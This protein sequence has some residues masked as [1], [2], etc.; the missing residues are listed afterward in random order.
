MCNI[1]STRGNRGCLGIPYFFALTVHNARVH[2]GVLKAN[3]A[4]GGC[5]R[6]HVATAP[7]G[8]RLAG[9][10]ASP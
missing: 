3:K 5:R 8:L 9:G 4:M 6:R 2:A 1:K 7:D 10:Q